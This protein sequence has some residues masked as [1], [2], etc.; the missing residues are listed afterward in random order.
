M[1]RP[2]QLPGFW[3]EYTP[4]KSAIAAL[5]QQ[6]LHNIDGYS[7]ADAYMKDFRASRKAR[8]P[9]APEQGGDHE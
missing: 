3:N 4:P 8:S 9:A 5:V 6:P 1:I 7:L 2:D